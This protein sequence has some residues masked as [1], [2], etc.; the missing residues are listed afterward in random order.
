MAANSK[1]FAEIYS[2]FNA[3]IYKKFDCGKF[4][5]PLNGGQPVCCTTHN[6][7]PVVAKEEWKLLK[8]RTDLWHAFTPFDGDTRKIVKELPNSCA[9]IE[10]KG[11][12][13]CERHN[14][15]LACRAFPFYPYFTRDGSLFGISYYWAFEDRCWVIANMTAID[16]DFVRELIAAYELLFEH[17]EDEEQAFIDNSA[18]HRRVFS[19]WERPIP[20]IARDGKLFKVEPKSNGRLI[21][22]NI[23]D[24]QIKDSPFASQKKY[25]RAIKEENGDYKNAPKLIST[26]LE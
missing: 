8:S 7:V 24:F 1:I 9:A 22:A 21:K 11:A 4:C 19:R 16:L 23:K 18:D 17:D 15:S 26:S 25:V 6:A 20:V 3:P 14:R 5:A 10:C 2:K 13:F 12:Q